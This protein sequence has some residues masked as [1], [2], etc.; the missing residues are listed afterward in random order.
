MDGTVPDFAN[1]GKPTTNPTF[2]SQSKRIT[3]VFDGFISIFFRPRVGMICMIHE[4]RSPPRK[5]FG[6]KTGAS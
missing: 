5:K 1:Q 4:I 6:R 2:V 3:T